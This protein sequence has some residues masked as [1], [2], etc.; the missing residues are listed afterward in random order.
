M[1]APS[2]AEILAVNSF[3][4]LTA[5]NKIFC[6]ITKHEMPPKADIVLGHINGQKFQKTKEWYMYDYSEFEPYIVPDRQNSSKL[7]CKLT[8]QTLNKIPAEVRKHSA[9][10][11]FLRFVLSAITW[12]S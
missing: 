9:G 2:L 11:K 12:E 6:S 8:G 7:H 3:L 1:A 5:E 4:T 10:K